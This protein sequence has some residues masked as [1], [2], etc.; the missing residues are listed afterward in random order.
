M[1]RGALLRSA[2]GRGRV[3]AGISHIK[4]SEKE[5]KQWL[6]SRKA[7]EKESARGRGYGGVAGGGAGF[8]ASILLDMIAPGIGTAT[9]PWLMA[10]G[11]GLGS[12]YGQERL[13]EASPE[14][15]GRPGIGIWD[16]AAGREER[17]AETKGRK[18]IMGTRAFSDAQTAFWLSQILGG[19]QGAGAGAGE[20][21]PIQQGLSMPALPRKPT[22]SFPRLD[23][24]QRRGL[25]QNL[26][27]Q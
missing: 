11:A 18:D 23:M 13:T 26:R 21:F 24:L 1:A 15:R 10:G 7:F 2:A 17:E 25:I 9:R 22:A 5:R 4:E 16:I 27:M 19:L 8:V 20:T 3:W 14:A 6:K 12:R